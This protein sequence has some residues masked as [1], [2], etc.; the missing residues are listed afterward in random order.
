MLNQK[1]R[2]VHDFIEK[3]IALKNLIKRNSDHKPEDKK[4]IFHF[5]LTQISF[6]PEED[7]VKFV[8]IQYK[9]NISKIYQIVLKMKK[10]K[11][12]LMIKSKNPVYIYGD[13]DIITNMNFHKADQEFMEEIISKD[14]LEQFY[15]EEYQ[16]AGLKKK[17]KTE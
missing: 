1:K 9:P 14:M 6:K 7:S 2:I 16:M 13:L 11:R 5:P 4:H 3:T 17:I 10:D 12:S 15:S 8:Y